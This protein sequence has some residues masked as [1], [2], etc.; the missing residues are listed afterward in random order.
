MTIA[1]ALTSTVFVAWLSAMSYSFTRSAFINAGLQ[2]ARRETEQAEVLA[3]DMML[4]ELRLASFSGSGVALSGVR[5]AAADRVEVL[6]DLNG[7]G[8]T[9]DTSERI[10]YSYDASKRAV[11]RATGGASPQPFVRGLVAGGFSLRYLDRNGVEISPAAMTLEK[12]ALIGAVSVRLEI[13][14]PAIAPV[15]GAS[16]P[17]IVT[18]LV[19]LRNQ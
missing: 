1:E 12:R 4:R 16:R 19:A 3:V 5:V 15:A 2:Q 17:G 10:A 7:D 18:A 14:L 8:D 6:A 9:D 13:E 11:M